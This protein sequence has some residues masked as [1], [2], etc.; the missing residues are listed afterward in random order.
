MSV[1]GKWQG[2]H[3]GNWRIKTNFLLLRDKSE[4]SLRNMTLGA[5][6]WLFGGLHVDLIVHRFPLGKTT[7]PSFY[8][9]HSPSQRHRGASQ[10][11]EER[12]E[13]AGTRCCD[14][15]DAP[16]C[17]NLNSSVKQGRPEDEAAGASSSS[18]PGA[19]SPRWGAGGLRKKY[20]NSSV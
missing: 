2:T 9:F 1:K 15:S 14:W 10:A 4:T 6:T 18:E 20:Q 11:W 8:L 13:T 16:R 17:T 19:R 7:L 5:E 12:R 3:L